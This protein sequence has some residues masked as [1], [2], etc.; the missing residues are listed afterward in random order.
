MW[1]PANWA[2]EASGRWLVATCG[3]APGKGDGILGVS[4]RKKHGEAG[5]A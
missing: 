2:A 4:S 1:Q 5:S 3:L